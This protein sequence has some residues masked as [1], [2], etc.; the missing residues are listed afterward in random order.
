VTGPLEHIF[1]AFSATKVGKIIGATVVCGLLPL[2]FRRR[3]P[4]AT[5]TPIEVWYLVFAIFGFVV[6]LLL[7]WP[8]FTAGFGCS[9]FGI[10]LAATAVSAY[11]HPRPGFDARDPQSLFALIPGAISLLI[12]L[13]ILIWAY[14]RLRNA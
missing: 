10:L 5:G 14:K 2:L 7:T 13:A 3:L 1:G 4:E 6:A 12:G 9:G 8:R 11:Y